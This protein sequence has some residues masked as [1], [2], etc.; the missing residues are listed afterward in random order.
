LISLILSGGVG[1]RLWPL[2]REKLPKQFSPLFEPSLFSQTVKRQEVMGEV[3]VCTSE[4]MR[5]LTESAQRH[6]GLNITEAF[7][8]PHGRNT[9]PAI[10][11]VCQWL[12]QKGRGQEVM[13]VFPS[14]HWIEKR[15]VFYEVLKLAEQCALQKQ[16]VTIGLQPTYPATGFGYIHCGGQSVASL[17]QRQAFPVQSFKE[18][19]SFEVAKS[20][21]EQGQYFWNS[22]MFVF[23]VDTMA[24]AF[25][26][27]L[28]ETWTLLSELKTDLSNLTDIYDRLD[29]ESIDF[30]I[31]EKASNQVN[32]P[33]DVGW[34]DLGS[35][36]DMAVAAQDARQ[37]ERRLFEKSRN[38]YV[39]SDTS[40]W[41]CLSHVDDLLVVDTE[42]ALLVTRKGESQ[43]VK[44]LVDQ[45]KKK[46]ATVVTDHVFENRPWGYYRNLYEEKNFKAKV[47]QVDPGQQL[48]Y[49][50]HQKRAEIWVTVEGT[51]EVVLNDEVIPVQKGV[52][53]NIP[54][55]AKHRMRNT[56]SAPLK[57][58]EVQLGDYFGEDDITRYQ[59]DYQRV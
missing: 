48:S 25:E 12:V 17:G 40:K 52:V 11:L 38:C 14:D 26:S 6:D 2:S 3:F 58:V 37:T 59:D 8:E 34:S 31:M 53:V 43:S 47:I 46:K 35:W 16:I 45:L 51:G 49:Q 32:V 55:Q 54:L 20:Y 41:V 5:T 56:G 22:G 23:Q 30:G 4:S 10:G 21:I 36:D 42:D 50:S 19:P 27:Y 28:P 39:Y 44:N 57:F 15:D 18:K 29:S 24:K 7:Y 33:C 1:T 13:G 9:A